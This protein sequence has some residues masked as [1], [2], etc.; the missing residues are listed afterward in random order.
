MMSKYVGFVFV[1]LSAS[2][3]PLSRALTASMPL[4]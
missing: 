3:R 4:R 2:F 1:S